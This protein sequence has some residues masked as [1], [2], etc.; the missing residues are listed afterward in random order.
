MK[1]KKKKSENDCERNFKEDFPKNC[2]GE[3]S[4]SSS[5]RRTHDGFGEL[6]SNSP[7][8]VVQYIYRNSVVSF[9]EQK[10]FVLKTVFLLAFGL[11]M[12]EGVGEDSRHGIGHVDIRVG[13]F[14]FFSVI[15]AMTCA[16]RWGVTHV[17]NYHYWA[18]LTLSR[19]HYFRYKECIGGWHS[20]EAAF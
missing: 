1:L 2:L 5:R 11:G 7:R 3:L 10:A 6:P 17:G 13:S 16:L 18:L 8:R 9:R 4:N 20:L 12:C 14:I 19:D 15:I